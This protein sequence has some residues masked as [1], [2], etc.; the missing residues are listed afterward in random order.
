MS[1][2][3]L[4]ALVQPLAA[5]ASVLSPLIDSPYLPPPSAITAVVAQERGTEKFF[6]NCK[7]GSDTAPGTSPATALK[8][9]PKAVAVGAS[10][11]EV[12]GGICP[13]SG[14]VQI[15][16]PVIIH[17]DGK[18]AL[19]GGK[20]I[21]GWQASSSHPGEKVL[22]ADTADFPL[23]EIKLLRVGS[24]SLRRSRWPKLVGDGLTT[25]NFLFAM[26]WSSGAAAPDRLRAMH[27]LGIDPTKLPPHAD[28]KAAAG[29]A[30]LHVLGC[31]EK[32]SH[33]KG[34][35]IHLFYHVTSLV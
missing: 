22:V 35:K 4:A 5:S 17:G 21:Q 16:K 28:L 30:F 9:L 10:W 1:S 34:G 25:P 14:P 7:S 2:L 15:N 19:S 20:A 24:S 13:L 29:N 18:T 12:S 3:V 32:V 23:K 27:K 6:V 26:P 33:N 11:I 31:V 8:S